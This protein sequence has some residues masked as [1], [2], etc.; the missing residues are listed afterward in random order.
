M[1]GARIVAVLLALILFA[2]IANILVETPL[3]GLIAIPVDEVGGNLDTAPVVVTAVTTGGNTQLPPA[4]NPNP[5]AQQNSTTNMVA[6]VT[7][8]AN[9]PNGAI[10][11]LPGAGTYTIAV[12]GAYSTGTHDRSVVAVLVGGSA[13]TACGQYNEPCADFW[14]GDFNSAQNGQT[15]RDITANSIRVVA[16]DDLGSYANNSG[17]VTVTVTGN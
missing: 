1:G 5:P 3:K 2:L 9:D 10:I 17:T 8:S 11:S 12:S 16:V 14:V 15:V 13:V 7:V 4:N 6:S